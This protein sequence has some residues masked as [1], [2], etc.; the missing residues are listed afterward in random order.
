MALASAGGLI[1][2]GAM[3]GASKRGAAKSAWRGSSSKWR[4]RHNQ[5]ALNKAA[6]A[7]TWRQTRSNAPRRNAATRISNRVSASWQIISV[8]ASKWRNQAA[9]GGV[10]R[11]GAYQ[12][13]Q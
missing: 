5:N 2:G 1:N 4:Q 10:R 8:S 11:V 3:A 12:R 13:L 7:A 9:Y 6:S